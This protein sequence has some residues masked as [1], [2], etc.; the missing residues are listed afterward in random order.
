MRCVPWGDFH[1]GEQIVMLD[2]QPTPKQ[3]ARVLDRLRLKFPAAFTTPRPLCVGIFE[4]CACALW[5]SDCKQ[6]N[7][8]YMNSGL[9]LSAAL[10]QWCKSPAYLR[11]CVQDAPRIGLKGEVCGSVSLEEAAYA[12]QQLARRV[13]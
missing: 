10:D 6:E 12:Q 7:I 1:Q 3:V 11:Q 2:R 5:P 8:K 13:M 4:A 9:Q